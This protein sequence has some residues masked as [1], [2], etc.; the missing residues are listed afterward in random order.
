MNINLANNCRPKFKKQEAMW[1]ESR[2]GAPMTSYIPNKAIKMALKECRKRDSMATIASRTL[3]LPID[4]VCRR[5]V[6]KTRYKL[7][8]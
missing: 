4:P 8:V 7:P 6:F 1:I 5:K 2:E 3:F